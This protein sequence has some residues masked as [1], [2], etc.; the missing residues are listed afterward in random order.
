MSSAAAFVIAAVVTFI[1]TPVA[2]TVAL[3]T[4]FLDRPAGY[5]GHRAPTPYL[6]GCAIMAGLLAGAF[7]SGVVDHHLLP[8]VG[9]AALV[10]AM[11]TLDDKLNLA[12][13]LRLG[14]EIGVGVVLWNAGL[15]WTVFHDG[16]GDLVLT[17][18]WVVGV[19]NAFNLMDNMDGAAAT[20]AAVSAL[21]AGTLALATSESA[22][23]PLCFAVAGAC[24]G[25]LP[26]NLATP[27]KIF[28]G[29][30]GSLPVGLLVAALA[31]SVVR[32][33]YFGPSGVVVAALLVGL[34]ILDT[35]LVTISRSRAGCSVLTGGRDHMTHRLVRHL[36]APRRVALTLGSSQLVLCGLT[37]GVAKAGAGWELLAGAA[38]ALLGAALIWQFEASPLFKIARPPKPADADADAG[39]DRMTATNSLR[40]E[41]PDPVGREPVRRLPWD[42]PQPNRRKRRTAATET[43]AVL[44]EPARSPGT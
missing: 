43:P 25:F 30:G 36:G 2:I 33:G 40:G 1:S 18:V 32:R 15:G 9:C 34:V 28:M 5:K 11:G 39:R 38:C 14:V 26:R 16:A 37:V 20:T 8:L 27:A 42:S 21:G 12:V 29:D 6:G 31:M 7:A 22:L 13:G 19:M 10:W 41:T 17:V 35:T 24:I 4:G 3:R 23:A 44:P